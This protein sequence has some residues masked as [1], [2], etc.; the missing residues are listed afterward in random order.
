MRSDRHLEAAGGLEHDEGGAKLLEL[1]DQRLDPGLVVR[2]PA[3]LGCTVNR[4]VRVSLR[5]IDSDEDRFALWHLGL[6]GWR[7]RG[8]RLP[9]LHDAGSQAR[10]TVRD[11]VTATKARRPS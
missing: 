3:D 7:G 4:H 2:H 8:H 10:A 6:P 5:D 11:L 9:V 1:G